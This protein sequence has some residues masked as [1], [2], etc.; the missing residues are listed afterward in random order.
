[1]YRPRLTKTERE[2]A[3]RQIREIWL[4]SS[5]ARRAKAAQEVPKA[6]QKTPKPFD[7]AILRVIR[8]REESAQKKT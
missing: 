7:N 3:R 1:M 2:E 4:K 8:A 5:Y 6:V